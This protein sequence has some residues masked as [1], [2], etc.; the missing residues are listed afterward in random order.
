MQPFLGSQ[1]Q[2]SLLGDGDEI[3][4]VPQLHCANAIPAGHALQL[5]KSFTSALEN[6]SNVAQ[7]NDEPSPL[8]L[9]DCRLPFMP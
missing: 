3:A 1:R 8:G 5:T 4:E 6:P 7:R 9:A 2:A